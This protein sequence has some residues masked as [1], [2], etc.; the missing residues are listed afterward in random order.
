MKRSENSARICDF[1]FVRPE[2]TRFDPVGLGKSG[3]LEMR[4]CRFQEWN[5]V[6]I[7]AAG[8]SRPYKDSPTVS[9]NS[10]DIEALSIVSSKE[11]TN[12]D[13]RVRIQPRT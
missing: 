3:S 11:Q 2:S 12:A 1:S 6:R 7:S 8:T 4:F 13:Q 10:Q 5:R 9:P